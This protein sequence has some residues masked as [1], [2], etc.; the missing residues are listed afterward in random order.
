MEGINLSSVIA[1]SSDEAIIEDCPREWL[2]SQECPILDLDLRIDSLP[3]NSFKAQFDLKAKTPGEVS[4][5]V[6][7]FDAELID[8]VTLSTSPLS[9]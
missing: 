9:P 8:G 3:N 4:G 7:W 6:G 2:V 5:I 1:A